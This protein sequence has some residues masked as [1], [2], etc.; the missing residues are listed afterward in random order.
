MTTTPP[1]PD[2]SSSLPVVQSVVKSCDA[3]PSQ[4]EIKL[5]D[6]RMVYARYRWGLLT[7]SISPK[8]TEDIMDAV[9]GEEALVVRAGNALDGFMGLTQLMELSQHVLDWTQLGLS[10][11]KDG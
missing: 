7:V 4:W 8:P 9:C 5:R 10:A 11:K 3:C 6:S 1:S 2:N